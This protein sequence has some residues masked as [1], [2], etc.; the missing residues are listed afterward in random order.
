MPIRAS[1]FRTTCVG[2]VLAAWLGADITGTTAAAADPGGL[3]FAPGSV[4]DH[5]GVATGFVL[6]YIGADEYFFGALPFG[7]KSW[8]HRNISLQGNLLTANVV[9]HPVFRAGPAAL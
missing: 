4:P 6:D 8:G 2:M 9:E 3:V 1:V 5:F 7:R